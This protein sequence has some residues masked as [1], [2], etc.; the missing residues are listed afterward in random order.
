MRFAPW[1][2]PSWPERIQYCLNEK[3]YLRQFLKNGSI[4][5]DNNRAE[6]AIRPFVM[7]RKKLALFHVA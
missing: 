6:N 3:A 2:A 7:G 1:A 5:V 4:P